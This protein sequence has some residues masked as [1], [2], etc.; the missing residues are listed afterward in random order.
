M[1]YIHCYYESNK[2]LHKCAAT[3][4][5]KR[6]N[7]QT[8]KGKNRTTQNAEIL[9][10]NENSSWKAAIL[11]HWVWYKTHTMICW[12]SISV[13]LTYSVKAIA[14]MLKLL[15]IRNWWFPWY[16]LNWCINCK[17]FLVFIW[18]NWIVTWRAFSG[19]KIISRKYTAYEN[20]YVTNLGEII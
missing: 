13:I 4:H 7:Q 14:S 17:T 1:F 20:L 6:K 2:S 19:K 3:Q 15:L 8:K 9:R 18:K 12:V 10:W 5:S 16:S 11:G